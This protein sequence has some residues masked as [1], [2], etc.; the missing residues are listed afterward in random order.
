MRKMFKK[1]IKRGLMETTLEK[2]KL[3]VVTFCPPYV[4]F[5]GIKCIF[6]DGGLL[7]GIWTAEQV[8]AMPDDLIKQCLLR[9]SLDQKTLD[10]IEQDNKEFL[11]TPEY[12]RYS[13][14]LERIRLESNDWAVEICQGMPKEHREIFLYL[15]DKLFSYRECYEANCKEEVDDDCYDPQHV[16]C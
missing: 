9:S 4:I 11:K 10:N 12:E 1:I 13:D 15:K 6:C 2:P 3:P 14:E 5:N 8:E 7:L 16:G